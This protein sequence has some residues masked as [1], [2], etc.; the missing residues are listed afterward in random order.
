MRVTKR[1]CY[2]FNFP[3][4]RWEII[5]QFCITIQHQVSLVLNSNPCN[6]KSIVTTVE[7]SDS[8]NIEPYQQKDIKRES[9]IEIYS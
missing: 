3:C 5:V 8:K 9:P 2:I 1:M 4:A 6:S 7:V